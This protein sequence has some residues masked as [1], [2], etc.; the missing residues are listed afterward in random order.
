L[1][2]VVLVGAETVRQ[3]GY[4]PARA[5]EGFAAAREAAGQGPAAV[6]AVVTAGLDLDFSLPLFTGPLLPTLILTGAGA[7]PDRV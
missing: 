5:R 3:E 2:D 1:A 7:A 4:R 6:I